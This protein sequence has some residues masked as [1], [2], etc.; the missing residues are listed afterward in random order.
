ML[1][2]AVYFQEEPGANGTEILNGLIHVRP[3]IVPNFNHTQIMDVNGAKEHA[4]F[5]YLKVSMAPRITGLMAVLIH[6]MSVISFRNS[7]PKI[8]P[9]DKC[10]LYFTST[11]S[12]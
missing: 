2:T 3:G 4:L 10:K 11:Q 5:T 12:M 9:D 1:T 6:L 8:S 7:F